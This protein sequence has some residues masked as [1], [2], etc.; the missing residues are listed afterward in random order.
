MKTLKKTIE[1]LIYIFIFFLPWQIRWIYQP[2]YYKNQY[3]EYQSQSVYATE[4]L[5]GFILLLCIVFFIKKFNFKAFVEKYRPKR[6]FFFC[7]AA[8]AILSFIILNIIFSKNSEIAFYKI[9]HLIQAGAF[10]LLLIFFPL[11]LKKL[12][13]SV[14]S[15]GLI[16]SVLAVNQ[17]FNQKISA[18][19][20]LG[21]A[22]QDPGVLGTSVIE[23]SSDRFLRAYGSLP[24]PN[25]LAGFLI[26]VLLFIV[27]Q[28]F[29][30]TKRKKNTIILAAFVFV[31]IALLMTFS[32][33]AWLAFFI[34]FIFIFAMAGIKKKVWEKHKTQINKLIV[35]V[36]LIAA[37]FSIIKSDLIFTRFQFDQPLEIKSVTERFSGYENAWQI[38]KQNI[39]TG[40]G[41][42]N[43]TL[44]LS[45]L[46][47]DRQA[48]QLQP[49]HNGLFLAIIE[50]GIILSLIFIGITAFIIKNLS[51]LLKG[52]WFETEI[53][54][55]IAII[56]ALFVICLFDHFLWSLVFG[57]L[58]LAFSA[59]IIK[60]GI[61]KNSTPL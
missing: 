15:A 60:F 35:S 42:G 2:A 55:S 10:S 7:I 38:F 8:A 33:S 45:N 54:F 14:I 32:R 49:V 56:L 17:F 16:Q 19:K 51:K 40:T 58:L 29:T 13:W 50:M 23:T 18:N 36:L 46:Y 25:I 43:Y 34:S 1:Y 21:M 4:I 22:G 39:F 47:P 9:T 3:W 61:N 44:A 48:W 37:V 31:F 6:F 41:P 27:Y 59:L 26:I 52:K 5:F 12:S 53:I 28:Y 24:H 30:E 57:N 20:W 11:N